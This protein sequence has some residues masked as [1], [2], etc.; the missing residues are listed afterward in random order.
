MKALGELAAMMMKMP[1]MITA[2][3]KNQLFKPFSFLLLLEVQAQGVK[4][5]PL[6]LFIPQLNRTKCFGTDSV[7]FDLLSPPICVSD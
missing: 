3:T 4:T 6:L 5:P 1:V 7:T 2:G